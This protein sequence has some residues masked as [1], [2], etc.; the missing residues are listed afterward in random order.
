MAEYN[1][2]MELG[3]YINNLKTT[4][5]IEERRKGSDDQGV[6][7]L[8]K[9]IDFYSNELSGYSK[10]CGC[11]TWQDVE[12]DI[13]SGGEVSGRKKENFL[14]VIRDIVPAAKYVDKHRLGGKERRLLEVINKALGKD[15]EIRR[16][17]AEYI[18][19]PEPID[20]RDSRKFLEE[21]HMRRYKKG[22][23]PKN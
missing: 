6:K 8:E 17:L 12:A 19:N 18:L 11:R 13:K 21:E 2:S 9:L 5:T 4:K 14:Q 3:S 16:E 1:K 15:P 7:A 23:H 10:G 20:L 22:E